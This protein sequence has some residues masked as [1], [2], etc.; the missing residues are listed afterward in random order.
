MKAMVLKDVAPIA[1]SPLWIAG[2]LLVNLVGCSPSCEIE[3]RASR[4]ER[5]AAE[6][7]AS[8]VSSLLSHPSPEVLLDTDAD[9]VRDYVRMRHQRGDVVA[10][11]ALIRVRGPWQR[12]TWFP[13]MCEEFAGGFCGQRP[14]R[15]P[16]ADTTFAAVKSLTSARFHREARVR[17]AVA[18]KYDAPELAKKVLREEYGTVDVSSWEVFPASRTLCGPHLWDLGLRVPTEIGSSREAR[19]M[20]L[21]LGLGD[22]ADQ[23]AQADWAAEA[24]RR[25]NKRLRQKLIA[26]RLDELGELFDRLAAAQVLG[27]LYLEARSNLGAPADANQS[28]SVFE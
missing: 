3:A 20:L 9:A 14:L 4:K 10:L 5:L 23:D 17:A 22:N 27:K 13:V 11:A 18:L 2:L 19:R 21:L 15:A 28:G 24:A 12:A 6:R 7:E 1:S 25:Y 16:V 26:G 8:V